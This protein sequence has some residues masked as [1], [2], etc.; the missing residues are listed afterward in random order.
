MENYERYGCLDVESLR[1]LFF[2]SKRYTLVRSE[3]FCE[4][5]GEK[6]WIARYIC[7]GT[8]RK[9]YYVFRHK[10]FF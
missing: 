10:F 7:I 6:M 9:K 4:R 2:I 5:R 3:S 8:L 1:G